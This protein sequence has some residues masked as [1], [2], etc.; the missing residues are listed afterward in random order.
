MTELGKSIVESVRFVTAIGEECSRL[1]NLI[2]QEISH[3]LLEAFEGQ[4]IADAKWASTS[5]NG[6]EGWVCEEFGFSLGISRPG[7]E[8]PCGWLVLQISLNGPGV[9]ALAAPVPLVHVGFWGDA[10]AFADFSMAFPIPLE[11]YTITV[12]HERLLKWDQG[13]Y[14]EWTYSLPLT[15][16]NDPT[17]IQ[18]AVIAPVKALLGGTQDE[19]GAALAAAGALR[20]SFTD[21]GGALLAQL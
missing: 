3:M 4:Y 1:A 2:K 17:D 19:A 6:A 13:E 15:S 16:L 20:Y 7:E 5:R 11:G 14:S 10:L 12:E 21:E 9:A 8:P 18:R